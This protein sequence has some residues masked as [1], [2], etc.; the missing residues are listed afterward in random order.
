MG[1]QAHRGSLEASSF[2]KL[3]WKVGKVVYSNSMKQSKPSNIINS[4]AELT[5]DDHST[6][7]VL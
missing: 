7:L 6:D 5:V 2:S 1:Y 4:Q 3:W